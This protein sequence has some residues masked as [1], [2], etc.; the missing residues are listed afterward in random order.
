MIQD[1]FPVILVTPKGA[2]SSD[3]LALM[4]DLKQLRAEQ[5]IISDDTNLLQDADF[6]L[7]IPAGIPEWLTPIVAVLPGQ[8]FAMALAQ[9]KGL[10]PDQPVG[11]QKV[12]ETF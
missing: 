5:L 3:I 8:L 1:G 7:P 6:A 9:I 12:T 2:V 10:D 4:G 11:L